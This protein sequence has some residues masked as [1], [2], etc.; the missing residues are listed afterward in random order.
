[1]TALV[2]S[3]SS[4]LPAI[5][6]VLHG[7]RRDT[8]CARISSPNASHKKRVFLGALQIYEFGDVRCV[9]GWME[10]QA[11]NGRVRSIDRQRNSSFGITAFV[12]DRAMT[13]MHGKVRPNLRMNG[14]VDGIRIP[15][16]TRV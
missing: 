13:P 14:L 4:S 6:G 8:R 9:G 2:F 10:K 15:I 7:E 12:T 5:W 16:K 11:N 1:M 3:K